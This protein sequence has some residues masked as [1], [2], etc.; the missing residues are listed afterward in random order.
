MAKKNKL[1]FL[2]RQH[3]INRKC[4]KNITVGQEIKLK[5]RL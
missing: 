3:H 4:F 1:L 5:R 2:K